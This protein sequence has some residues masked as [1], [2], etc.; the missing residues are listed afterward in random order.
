MCLGSAPSEMVYIYQVPNGGFFLLKKFKKKLFCCFLSF[1][2]VFL[3][4]LLFSSVKVYAPC[5]QGYQSFGEICIDINE[6]TPPQRLEAVNQTDEQTEH[7]RGPCDSNAECINTIG[8][9]QCVCRE[10]YGGDG[11][12]CAGIYIC[13]YTECNVTIP[14][15]IPSRI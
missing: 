6:C 5:K 13:V 11:L 4:L 8:S 12:R 15:P 10:G 1:F 2:F 7:H 14:P 9:F 3:S